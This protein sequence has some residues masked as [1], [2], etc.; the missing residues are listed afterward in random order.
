[1]AEVF[2]A[3]WEVAPFVLRPVVRSSSL[4]CFLLANGCFGA[5]SHGQGVDVLA[6][7]QATN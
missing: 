4:S 1:M 7:C 3:A 2:P 5:Q 6:A